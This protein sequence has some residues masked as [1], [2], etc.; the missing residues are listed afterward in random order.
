MLTIVST[1][2]LFSDINITIILI[3]INYYLIRSVKYLNIFWVVVVY[4]EENT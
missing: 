1:L 3:I 2:I 4:K